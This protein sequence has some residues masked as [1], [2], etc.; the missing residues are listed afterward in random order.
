M[1]HYPPSISGLYCSLTSENLQA[2]TANFI[3]GKTNRQ[4]KKNK[5]KSLKH[6]FLCHSVIEPEEMIETQ[7]DSLGSMDNELIIAPKY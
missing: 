6:A 4:T 2:E 7:A 5:N 3:L 1:K